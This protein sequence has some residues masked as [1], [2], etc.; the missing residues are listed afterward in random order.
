MAAF[1]ICLQSGKQRKSRVGEGRQLCCFFNKKISGDKGSVRR[2]VVMQQPVN[3]SPKFGAKSSNNFKQAPQNN[4]AV[5]GTDC[6]ARQD[7]FFENNSL[8]VEENDEHALD[9]AFRLFGP[10]LW[11]NYF[12]VSRP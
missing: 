4:T 2:C 12:F 7:E 1:Q 5:C 9:F 6:S 11:E 8:D 3:L 10:V